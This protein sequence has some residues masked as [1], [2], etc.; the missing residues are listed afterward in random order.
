MVTL[1]LAPLW[2]LEY[3]SALLVFI[4][5]ILSLRLGRRLV[6]Q[7][8]ENALWL[9]LNWLAIALV[10]LAV[11]HLISHTLH[12]LITYWNLPNLA[13]VQRI[14]GGFDSV[15]YVV[16]AAITLFFHRIQRL[17]LR[18]ETDHHYLEE[19]SHEI[20]ALN[21]EMEALV[22]E[23]TMSEMA[24]GMAH[25]IR[26]PLHIIGGF[27][28]RLLRKTDE[29]DPSRA[30]ATAIA[31]EARR[32]EQMV[33]RFETLAM[34]KTSFFAQE[35]LNVIVR[36]TMDLLL[37]DLKAKNIALVKELC[38][39]PLVGRFNKHLLKVALAHLVRNAVEA[40]PRGGTVLVRTAMEQQFAVLILRDT[41]RGMPEEVVEKVFVPFYTTKIGGT[42]LGMVFVRQIVDEHR[43]VITLESKVG[44]GT[45]VTIRLPHR[46][47]DRPEVVDEFPPAAPPGTLA[48][49][50]TQGPGPGKA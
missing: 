1:P 5:T 17:Y 32:I 41:G 21:R 50:S 3:L 18:M 27:S 13:L 28:H 11:T 23:R 47:T 12:D 34:R 20:L 24:M 29:D 2:I 39:E 19:T 4:L 8:P 26:N 48:A 15:V 46:F 37:P 30:W 38:P 42:G 35:D 9:F 44:Q 43:G 33:E 22:M 6:D 25:G 40:T 49:P 45:T 7:D 10:I 16:I 14:F 36:S 31:E